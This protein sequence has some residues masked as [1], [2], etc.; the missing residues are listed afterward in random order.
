MAKSTNTP[1]KQASTTAYY[2]KHVPEEQVATDGNAKR[3]GL[4]FL[5]KLGIFL[6]FPFLVGIM[7]L[8]LGYLSSLKDPERKMDLDKDF[9]MP[10]LL[11]LAMVAIIGMQTNGYSTTEVKPLV[12]WPKVKRVKKFVRKGEEEEKNERSYSKKD[13]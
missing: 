5:G 2:G 7:G 1:K 9:I 12:K 13:N 4:T 8:Y 6:G 3:P 10:F 11:A